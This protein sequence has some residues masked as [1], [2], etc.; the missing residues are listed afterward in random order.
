[1]VFWEKM[2]TLIIYF[3]NFNLLGILEMLV[4]SLL[5]REINW[6]SITIKYRTCVSR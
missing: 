6:V 5:S 3:S 2:L 4:I 1:M